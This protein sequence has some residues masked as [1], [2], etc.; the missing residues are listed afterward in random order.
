[1]ADWRAGNQELATVQ[2]SLYA[3]GHVVI[4]RAFPPA[5]RTCKARLARVLHIH[6]HI[7]MLLGHVQIDA[8]HRPWLVQPQQM[9]VQLLAFQRAPPWLNLRGGTVNPQKCLKNQK[10]VT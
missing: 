7:H 6:I 2:M 9:P 4:H 5:V 8:F 10:M 1:M 3:L